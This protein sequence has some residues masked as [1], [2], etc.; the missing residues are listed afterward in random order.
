MIDQAVK[1]FDLDVSRCFLIGDKKGDLE[2]AHSGL[3]A[4]V[5]VKSS[6][7]AEQAL[8]AH[9][10]GVLPIVYVAESFPQA[11]AWIL[12]EAAQRQHR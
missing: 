9:R 8:V 5:L 3:V 2:A 6:P 11:I 1:D 12:Q 10:E 4:G 7:Y